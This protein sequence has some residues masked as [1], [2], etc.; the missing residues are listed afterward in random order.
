M[1]LMLSVLAWFLGEG[2]CPACDSR[3][4]EHEAEY[5]VCKQCSAVVDFS[6]GRWQFAG[7][8]EWYQLPGIF[9]INWD[10]AA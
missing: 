6:N 2:G 9:G 4:I 3:L 5:H 8:T 1:N 7:G 10:K